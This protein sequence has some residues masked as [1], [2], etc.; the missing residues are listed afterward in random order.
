[1]ATTVVR[2]VAWGW[3]Q[4]DGGIGTWHGGE[5]GGGTGRHET[6]NSIVYVFLIFYVPK[7]TR[8]ASTAVL[9]SVL[10]T[11]AGSFAK[12]PLSLN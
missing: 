12:R 8:Y 3:H 4:V 2:R 5:G 9:T 1:M 6:G 7:L 11:R 10:H